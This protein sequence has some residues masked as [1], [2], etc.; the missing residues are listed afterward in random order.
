MKTLSYALAIALVHGT[1]LAQEIPGIVIDVPAGDRLVVDTADSRMA[2]TLAGIEAPRPSEPN[3]EASRKSLA[4]L[5]YRQAAT[6]MPTGTA[7]DGNMRAEVS[8]AGVR[9]DEAQL[10]RGMARLRPRL[11]VDSALQHAEEMARRARLGI[12]AEEAGPLPGGSRAGTVV[13]LPLP[14]SLR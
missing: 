13:P 10:R 12:W 4:D 11:E 3:G 7:L 6:V 8:C 2:V 1:V 5:C 14:G 9:A